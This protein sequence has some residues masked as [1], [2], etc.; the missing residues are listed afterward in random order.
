MS[1]MP[2]FPNTAHCIPHHSHRDL[3]NIQI[4]PHT[5]THVTSSLQT[6]SLQTTVTYCPYMAFSILCDLV[7]AYLYPQRLSP[8]TV[9]F[10]VLKLARRSCPR[11]FAHEPPTFALAWNVSLPVFYMTRSYY[12][13]RFLRSVISARRVPDL[14]LQ[15]SA[16][17]L[18]LP[19]CTLVT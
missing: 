12:S 8:A 19:Y 18:S 9:A 3:F 11:T 16:V 1:Q 10:S 6:Q 17:L 13:S 7:A 15:S 4:R 2:H 14:L 5:R